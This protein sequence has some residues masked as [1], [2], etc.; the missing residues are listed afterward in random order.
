M[1]QVS[2]GLA[3]WLI[4]ILGTHLKEIMLSIELASVHNKQDLI[5]RIHRLCLITTT[6]SVVLQRFRIN[7]FGQKKLW[8]CCFATQNNGKGFFVVFQVSLGILFRRFCYTFHC[9]LLLRAF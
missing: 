3:R 5:S 6:I 4:N 9:F 8:L 2:S 1:A 7:Q